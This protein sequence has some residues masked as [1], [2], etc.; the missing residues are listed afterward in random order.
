MIP[1]SLRDAIGMP[2]G[3]EVEIRLLDG[4]LVVSP[5]TFASGSRTATHG[6]SLLTRDERAAEN[7]DRVGAD[8][9]WVA[10]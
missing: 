1:K 9:M 10:T 8:V 3:G 2:D 6:A 5:P 7:C 4:E